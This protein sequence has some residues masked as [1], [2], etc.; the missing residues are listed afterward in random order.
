MGAIIDMTHVKTIFSLSLGT[1]RYLIGNTLCNSD[2]SVTQ[3]IHIL[4]FFTTNNI[5]YKPLR[6]HPEE[7]NLENERSREWVPFFLSNDPKTPCPKR[8]EHDGRKEVVHHLT[9]KLFP[10]GHESKQCSPS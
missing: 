2:D 1:D 8:Y 5:F 9:G 4:H 10:Q 6:R 3:L 7:S